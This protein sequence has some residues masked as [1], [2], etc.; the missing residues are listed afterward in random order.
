[1][2]VPNRTTGSAP[3]KWDEYDETTVLSIEYTDGF[4]S[5]VVLVRFKTT[6]RSPDP[7]WIWR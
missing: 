1:M 6:Y 7:M 5:S 4:G 2:L 3:S